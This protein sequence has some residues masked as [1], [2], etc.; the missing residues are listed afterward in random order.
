MYFAEA[1]AGGSAS[2]ISVAR[3]DRVSSHRNVVM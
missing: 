2:L 3:N 1:V